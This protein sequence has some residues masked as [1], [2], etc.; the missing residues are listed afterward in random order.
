MKT[1]GANKI[2]IERLRQSIQPKAEFW[3]TISMRVFLW[4]NRLA[5][6]TEDSSSAFS[7]QY[8]LERLPRQRIR[9][10]DGDG[11]GDTIGQKVRRFKCSKNDV[12][13]GAT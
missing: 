6:R 2:R 12:F 1:P 4:R 10:N 5:E 9:D 11:D 13:A 3:R 8:Q 7:R